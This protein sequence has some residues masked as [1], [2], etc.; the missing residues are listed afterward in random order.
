MTKSEYPLGQFES[1]GLN[2]AD[3]ADNSIVFR[4]TRKVAELVPGFVWDNLDLLVS[5]AICAGGFWALRSVDRKFKP[6]EKHPYITTLA[7][8]SFGVA[9]GIIRRLSR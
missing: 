5:A 6:V 8:A 1:N 2:W 9:G 4:G 7:A 3:F